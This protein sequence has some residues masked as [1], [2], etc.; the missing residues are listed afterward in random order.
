M[1]LLEK[2]VAEGFTLRMFPAYERHLGVEKYN[3]VT[4]LEPT[5]EGRW[6]RFGS[7]GYLLDEHIALLIERQG[8]K[9]FVFKA[10]EIIAEGELLAQYERFLNEL[11][12][13]LNAQ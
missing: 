11:N 6:H 5:P 13:I 2:L 10:Q 7:P 12:A 4:L 9:F 8:R 3:C 1:D